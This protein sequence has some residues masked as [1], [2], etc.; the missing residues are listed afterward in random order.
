MGASMQNFY[1]IKYVKKNFSDYRVSL[2]NF[3]LFPYKTRNIWEYYT[4]VSS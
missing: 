1:S 2:K 4:P 3:T